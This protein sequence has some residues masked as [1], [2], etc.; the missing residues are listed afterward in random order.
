MTCPKCGSEN[1]NVTIEQV[2]GKTKTRGMG[3]LWGIGR[4]LLILG[5]GGLW[6]LIGKRKNTSK[7][8]F[9]SRT[10]AICQNCGHKWN[11]R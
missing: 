5:T 6:L 4:A 10:V 11:V 2:S 7:V 9:K 1:V 8:K 3:C